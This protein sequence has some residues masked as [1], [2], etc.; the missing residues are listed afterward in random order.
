MF[1]R[2]RMYNSCP[3]QQFALISNKQC[4][5]ARDYRAPFI[6]LCDRQKRYREDHHNA[7]QDVGNTPHLAT[8]S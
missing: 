2:F 3:M 4:T 6:L 5:R 7:I 1:S 8:I